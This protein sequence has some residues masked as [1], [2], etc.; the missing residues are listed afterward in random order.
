M[1][2]HQCPLVSWKV[3]PIISFLMAVTERT[4]FLS[5]FLVAVALGVSAL[6]IHLGFCKRHNIILISSSLHSPMSL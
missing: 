1:H 2:R 5:W 4:S 3:G 6:E